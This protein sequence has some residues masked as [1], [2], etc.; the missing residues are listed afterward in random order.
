[1][2]RFNDW[3][4]TIE[5]IRNHRDDGHPL[6]PVESA[7][8]TVPGIHLSVDD[9]GTDDDDPICDSFDYSDTKPAEGPAD[10]VVCLALA[11]EALGVD[12]N[13][14]P[15]PA[16]NVSVCVWKL[17]TFDHRK[18]EWR[19]ANVGGEEAF[20]QLLGNMMRW[21]AEGQE[22]RLEWSELN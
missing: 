19:T 20:S 14:K 15:L 4:A 12:N 5:R 21:K 10:C 11:R 22:V 9:P 6:H 17:K 2:T 13:G 8:Q 7:S 3:A 18:K 1:M 16:V